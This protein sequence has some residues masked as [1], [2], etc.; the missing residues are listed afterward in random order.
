M[1]Y[2]FQGP[3]LLTTVLFLTVEQSLTPS[4]GNAEAG[5]TLRSD[6]EESWLQGGGPGLLTAAPAGG[7]TSQ[8]R[9]GS[10]RFTREVPSQ[11]FLSLQLSVHR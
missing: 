9:R 10:T 8:P 4:P 11:G 6:V 2:D 7:I 5:T 3:L 1:K